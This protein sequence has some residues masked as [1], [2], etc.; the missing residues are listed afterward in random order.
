MTQIDSIVVSSYT[1]IGALFVFYFFITY[2]QKQI[3]CLLRYSFSSVFLITGFVFFSAAGKVMTGYSK[4]FT[5]ITLW[6]SFL[7]ALAGFIAVLRIVYLNK[8]KLNE[9]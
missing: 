6:S 9:N 3:D 7:L 8:Q 4:T 2:V 1:V 5:H